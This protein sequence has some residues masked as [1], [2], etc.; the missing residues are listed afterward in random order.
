M[1]V[2]WLGC[3]A[4]AAAASH[5]EAQEV[6][7]LNHSEAHEQQTRRLARAVPVYV[8]E[9]HAQ[10]SNIFRTGNRNAAS[11]LWSSWILERA[12]ALSKPNL[13]A[14]FGAFCPISGSIV[15][16]SAYNKYQFSLTSVASA[17]PS[18]GFVHFCCE[19]CVCDTFDM[20]RADQKTIELADGVSE[21]LT[22][23]VIGDPCTDPEALAEPFYDASTGHTTTLA[24]RAPEVACDN[25]RLRGA[26]FSDGGGVII[27]LLAAAPPLGAAPQAP[28][29]GRVQSAGG[30][31]FVDAREY[32]GYCAQRAAD[33]YT[34][35]MGLIF[36]KVA[37]ITSLDPAL[38]AS[39]PAPPALPPPRAPPAAPPG[40]PVDG[41]LVLAIVLPSVAVLA[42]LVATACCCCC[43]RRGEPPAETSTQEL[44][45]KAQV[46][47]SQDGPLEL[48]VGVTPATGRAM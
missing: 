48:E 31:S 45:E 27:G 33:G 44:P 21:T 42:A 3:L 6:Q 43:R 35:G 1:C 8:D 36:R 46:A 32:A 18:V 30:Q 2:M 25:G 40:E 9:M 20:V 26:T 41:L 5:S 13:V 11:H 37:E 39:P 19:P 38:P 4:T 10:Y 14:L 34:G 15:R 47:S 24:V 23:A 12:A 16:A 17:E 7:S 22:F 29:P 28:T